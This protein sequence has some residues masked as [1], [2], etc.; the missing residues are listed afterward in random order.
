MITPLVEFRNTPS[1]KFHILPENILSHINSVDRVE[2]GPNA[3]SPTIQGSSGRYW[4]YH[5]AQTDN[6]I[7]FLGSRIT[8]LYTPKH[9]KIETIEVTAQW[10]KHNGELVIDTPAILS[11]PP[12]VFHRVSSGQDGSLSLNLAVHEKGFSLVDNFDI[13]EVDTE[14][15]RYSV[16]RSGFLDQ[17]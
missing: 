16:I 14:T 10:V 3:V 17:K 1:V 11:W 6:L 12:C 15:G 5:K 8:E 7:V 9:G 2:H 13:Y 4:Y